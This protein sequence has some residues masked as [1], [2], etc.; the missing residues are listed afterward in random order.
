MEAKG[1]YTTPADR[2]GLAITQKYFAK[3]YNL[4]RAHLSHNRLGLQVM[5]L[6]LGSYMW[7]NVKPE[8]IDNPI[9]KEIKRWIS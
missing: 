4:T 3:R 6:F 8:W 5:V 7:I 1:T 2:H 9:K